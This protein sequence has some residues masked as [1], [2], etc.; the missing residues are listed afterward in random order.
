MRPGVLTRPPGDGAGLVW[1][2]DVDPAASRRG[3]FVRSV[4]GDDMMQI[5]NDTG[6]RPRDFGVRR[7]I[8]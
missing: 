1:L 7:L 4:S 6:F 5:L 2:G 8:G 3:L